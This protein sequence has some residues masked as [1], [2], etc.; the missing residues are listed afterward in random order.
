L[1]VISGAD[2]ESAFGHASPTI[3][4]VQLVPDMVGRQ[5]AELL[6][7]LMSGERASAKPILLRPRGVVARQ[8]TDLMFIPD[9]DVVSA[10]KFI[11]AHAGE[12]IGVPDILKH[13]PVTRR[14]LEY[15]FRV[16]LHR[17][18]RQELERKRMELAQRYLVETDWTMARIAE[19]TGFST[20]AYFATIFRLTTGM[21][22][23]TFRQR[24]GIES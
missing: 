23:S 14:T 19:A 17:S 20:S 7:R 5:A 4:A 13:V 2:E 3:S 24:Q 21:T 15:R 9:P 12:P 8:S 6:N 10:L 11:E 22:P 16:W 1:A 18:P